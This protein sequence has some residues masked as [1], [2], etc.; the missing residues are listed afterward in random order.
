[1]AERMPCP[2]AAEHPQATTRGTK[3]YRW[4]ITRARVPAGPQREEREAVTFRYRRPRAA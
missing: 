2:T 1:M 4:E 3:F